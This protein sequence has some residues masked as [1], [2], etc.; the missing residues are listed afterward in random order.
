MQLKPRNSR[1]APRPVVDRQ[2]RTVPETDDGL[3]GVFSN[4]LIKQAIP[5][6]EDGG[7]N[8]NCIHRGIHLAFDPEEKSVEHHIGL[9][10]AQFVQESLH[11]LARSPN[12]VSLREDF[13]RAGILADD[14]EFGN[15]IK[16]APVVNGPEFGSKSP[17]RMGDVIS[18]RR[19]KKSLGPGR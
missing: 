12:Q 14:Q 19:S 10:D 8:R 3:N 9:A 5:V 6:V 17:G 18:A 16:A 2:I 15:S 11:S 7:L 13:V 1:W 4:D